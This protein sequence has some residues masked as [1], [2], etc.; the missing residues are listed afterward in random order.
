MVATAAVVA[1]VAGWSMPAHSRMMHAAGDADIGA[2]GV[3][4]S[5][6]VADEVPGV[7]LAGWVRVPRR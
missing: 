4:V 6:E 5:P 3:G 1:T 7:P 2:G